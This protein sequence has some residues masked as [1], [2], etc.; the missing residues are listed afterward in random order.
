MTITGDFPNVTLPGTPRI[1][2]AS[3]CAPRIFDLVIEGADPSL[4]SSYEVEAA[5]LINGL[6]YVLL[7]TQPVA[8]VNGG[9]PVSIDLNGLSTT[10]YS[11]LDITVRTR[12]KTPVAGGGFTFSSYS[13]EVYLRD[14]S[15]LAAPV[16]QPSPLWTCGVATG[17]A[18]HQPRDQIDLRSNLRSPIL[19][20]PSAYGTFDYVGDFTGFISGEKV[21]AEYTTCSGSNTSPPSA[22]ITVQDYASTSLPALDVPSAGA[23]AR[24]G[25][26][27]VTGAENGAR[28]H[29]TF[30]RGATST[31]GSRGC[32]GNE[33]CIIGVP[34]V[35]S[36]LQASDTLTVEQEL[37]PGVVSPPVTTTIAECDGSSPTFES[38][39]VGDSS[40]RIL[41]RAY[42]STVI[43]YGCPPNKFNG[44]TCTVG[45]SVLGSSYDSDI[46]LLSSPV[47]SGDTLAVTQRVDSNCPAVFATAQTIE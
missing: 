12:I 11:P 30:T 18:G 40:V 29:Y 10:Q 27:A 31:S 21:F 35:L 25:A 6:A 26:V 20:V 16:V 17:V 22:L 5:S 33:P 45:W 34:A 42:G 39:R 4:G 13:P 36:P 3:N 41:S 37:C 38:P 19:H 9:T 47:G 8:P 24:V 15:F 23:V 46:V 7:A 44:S 2:G 14:P 1:R 43:V 32:V 28:I